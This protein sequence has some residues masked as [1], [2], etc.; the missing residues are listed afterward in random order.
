[1]KMMD[2]DNTTSQIR[3]GMLILATFIVYV[4]LSFR[5]LPITWIRVI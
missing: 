4:Y 5:A 1:M 3:S 2:V